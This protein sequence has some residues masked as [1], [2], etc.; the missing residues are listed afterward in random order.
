L[1]AYKKSRNSGSE[2]RALSPSLRRADVTLKQSR[3]HQLMPLS[4]QSPKNTNKWPGG[5][6]R[7]VF[8]QKATPLI[9]VLAHYHKAFGRRFYLELS[10]R[11]PD[12]RQVSMTECAAES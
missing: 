4:R 5:W 6:R 11:G 1:R 7:G 10:Q 12:K 8:I 9:L 3:C 2:P